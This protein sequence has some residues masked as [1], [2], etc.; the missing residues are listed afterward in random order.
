MAWSQVTDNSPKRQFNDVPPQ[1]GDVLTFSD[2]LDAW[3]PRQPPGAAGGEANTATNVGG[4]GEVFKQKTGVDLEFRTLVPGA[5][6][7]ITQDTDTIEISATGAG[8]GE[9]PNVEYRTISAPE[10]AAKELTLA[11]TPNDPTK[12]M[13][14]TIGGCAQEYSVDYSITDDVLSWDSLG[15][16]GILEAG[17]KLR[18]VY[19]TTA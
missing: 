3:V 10:A 15:L 6:I 7:S 12:V 19:W 4:G 11:A 1:P 5:N 17:D 13:L 2:T 14:D 8:S 9:V 18:I 16:D